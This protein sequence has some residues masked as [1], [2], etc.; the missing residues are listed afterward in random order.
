MGRE[1]P[2]GFVEVTNRITA[3]PEALRDAE[4][5]FGYLAKQSIKTARRFNEAIADTIDSIAA[6]P[7]L[8]I[9]WNA[10]NARLTDLRWRKV[11]SFSSYLI[12]YRMV[13]DRLEIVR[14]LHGSRDLARLFG[15]E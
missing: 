5:I 14:I 7:H 9:R 15:I 2:R 11:E 10:R 4:E 13:E 3:L 6:D 8:G 12:F 1:T